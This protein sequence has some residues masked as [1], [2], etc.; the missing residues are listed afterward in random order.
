MPAHKPLVQDNQQPLIAGLLEQT[1]QR[2]S[3]SVG[4]IAYGGAP[5]TSAAAEAAIYHLECGGQ[6]VRARL[7]LNAGIAVGLA[8]D[9]SVAIAV[10]AELLH[11]AS[12]IHDDIQDEEHMRRARQTV[13]SLYGAK[14]AIC[15]GDLLLSSAYGYL[16]EFSDSRKLHQLM[17]LVHSRTAKV[18]HGQCADLVAQKIPVKDIAHYEAIAAAK[19]GALLGLPLELAL[20]ASGNDEAAE[21]GRL[22][23]EAFA[24]GYQIAD[25]IVDVQSDRGSF[26]KPAALNIV[27]VLEAAGYGVNSLGAARRL[28]LKHL[29]TASLAATRLPK[30]SGLFLKELSL[31]LS[32]QL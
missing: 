20:V 17:R 13:W 23:A 4:Q 22:A 3:A 6:R 24:V 10:T 28:C 29:N 21:V 11:N 15:A 16:S 31:Q 9:D 8:H 30:Q 25:D 26:D 12:L 1:E 19:S 18:I 14:V 5:Q 2:M 32:A 27:L 7:A